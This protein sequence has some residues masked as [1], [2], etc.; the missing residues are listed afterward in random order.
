MKT[1]FI[2]SLILFCAI[3]GCEK[4]DN[5]PTGKIVFYTNAQAMLNCGPFDVD[6]Y[7][8]G[9]K[10]GSISNPV[11]NEFEPNCSK[12]EFTIVVNR[13][14]GSY[15]CKAMACSS[16][17]WVHEIEVTEDTCLHVFLDIYNFNQ[18]EN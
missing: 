8:E 11:F 10:V 14:P 5:E 13:A 15:T 2:L 9:K 7:L 6:V 18:T 12:S 16:L 4:S 1:A 3:L 17:E